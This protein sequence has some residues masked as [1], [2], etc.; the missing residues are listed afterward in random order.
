[1]GSCC[2]VVDE[3]LVFVEDVGEGGAWCGMKGSDSALLDMAVLGVARDVYRA[4]L[5]SVS[6]FLPLP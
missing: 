4:I 3:R 1:M 6:S 2:I 5:E